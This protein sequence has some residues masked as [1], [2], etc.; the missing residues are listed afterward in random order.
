MFATPGLARDPHPALHFVEDE[1]DVVL[2]TDATHYAEPFGA[3]VIVST[4]ALDW[5][6]D[7]RGNVLTASFHE[8]LNLGLGTLLAFD[9]IL[10]ALSFRQREVDARGHH[11]WPRKLGEV[12]GLARIGVGQAHRV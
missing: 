9:N 8:L 1:Q 3:K 11:S 2:V 7:H 5:L 10:L 6:D 12:I 4:L